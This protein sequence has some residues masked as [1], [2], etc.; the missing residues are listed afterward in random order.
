M[1]DATYVWR[2]IFF[3]SRLLRVL[4]G[5]YHHSMAEL[6]VTLAEEALQSY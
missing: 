4:T 5:S 2:V 1:L 6:G 3:R